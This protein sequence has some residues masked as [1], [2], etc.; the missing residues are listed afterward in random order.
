MRLACHPLHANHTKLFPLYISLL[1]YGTGLQIP[2]RIRHRPSD[3]RRVAPPY[4]T[5]GDHNRPLQ[6]TDS[7]MP[8]HRRLNYSNILH[9]RTRDTT[10]N[11]CTHTHHPPSRNLRYH[12]VQLNTHIPSSRPSPRLQ[13]SA[14]HASVAVGMPSV[15]GNNS[16]ARPP[17]V[18]IMLPNNA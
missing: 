4:S 7:A 10:P 14:S 3:G 1:Y 17:I 11:T 5:T 9:T 8:N 13:Y 2:R 18:T 12:S 6:R 15:P 16:S